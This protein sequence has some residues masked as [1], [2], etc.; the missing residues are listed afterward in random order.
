M[1]GTA[2]GRH[3]LFRSAQSRAGPRYSGANRRGR[4]DGDSDPDRHATTVQFAY[5][6]LLVA[7]MPT[8]PKSSCTIPGCPNRVERGSRCAIHQTERHT[9]IDERRESSTKRGYDAEWRK[10]RATF[11]AEY[12]LCVRCLADGLPI[13]AT[14]VDHIKP[15]R[16]GGTHDYSNLQSLCHRCH[17]AKTMRELNRGRPGAQAP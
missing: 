2:T 4:C 17:S 10:I 1:R 13:V 5:A 11:L 12:P 6:W 16:H 8:R 7:V 15:L 3:H 9:L 14:E